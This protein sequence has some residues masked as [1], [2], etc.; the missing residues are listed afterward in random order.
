ML[1]FRPSLGSPE[2]KKAIES[3]VKQLQ[4]KVIDSNEWGKKVLAYPI[5][6]EKE[7]YYWLV[8]FSA[9]G[10][11][12]ARI[13]EILRHNESVIRYLVVKNENIKTPLKTKPK[14]KE[15]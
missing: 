3:V 2:Q 6:K 12:A 7:G 14:K 4:T 5:D 8:T 1:I 11:E 13:P 15:S 9:D 10:K